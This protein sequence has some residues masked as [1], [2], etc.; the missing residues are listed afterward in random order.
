MTPPLPTRMRVVAIATG[1]ISTSGLGPG[2]HRA[3]VVLGQPV[4][5]IAELV[6]EP[7]EVERVAQRVGAGRALGD[8]RLVQDAEHKR[9][10]H[11]A[12]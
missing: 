9:I 4:A 8:R 5:V 6:G 12:S 2:E 10:R 1:P 3:A 7:R 11:S